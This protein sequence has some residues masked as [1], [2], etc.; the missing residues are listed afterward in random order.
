MKEDL[1]KL[2][3]LGRE[4]YMEARRLHRAKYVPGK[5]YV[6]LA[7]LI[8]V[9]H[10]F[11]RVV[12]EDGEV[13]GGLAAYVEPFW[14]STDK[15]AQDL[16]LFIR[17]DKRGGIAA[18]RLVREYKHWAKERGAVITQFGIGTGVRVE[19]TRALL[20]HSG[21]I[22]YGLQFEAAEESEHVRQ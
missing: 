17:P 14:F 9:D 7:S 11:F 16:G 12:E 15:Y 22:A 4:M 8:G 20:E 6:T 1:P 19:K 18:T 21:F 13:V 5:V 2:V 3:E 10:G